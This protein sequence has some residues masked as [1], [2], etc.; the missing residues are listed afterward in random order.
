M[1]ECDSYMLLGLAQTM[2]YVRKCLCFEFNHIFKLFS[3]RLIKVQ[4]NQLF[5]SIINY[6]KWFNWLSLI[7]INYFK[8]ILYYM[9]VNNCYHLNNVLDC[10]C[11]IFKF[12]NKQN[13]WLALVN[14][15]K[16]DLD[17]R[18]VFNRLTLIIE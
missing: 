4:I 11:W 6:N 16:L 10:S 2:H 18:F 9:F 13:N 1:M 14:D 17:M 8:L 12:N 3:K 7:I 5:L 15:I